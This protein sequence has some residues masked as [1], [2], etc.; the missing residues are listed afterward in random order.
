MISLASKEQGAKVA[1]DAQGA[2]AAS[3][4]VYA[5]LC[6]QPTPARLCAGLKW[7]CLG[8]SIA[9]IEKLQSASAAALV[10]A[11]LQL[12]EEYNFHFGRAAQVAPLSP[13]GLEG[14]HV[15]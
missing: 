8:V 7:Y 5:A 3:A 4:S 15:A 1:D 2:A 13:H 14:P 12:F 11:L 10:K 6:L 9:A